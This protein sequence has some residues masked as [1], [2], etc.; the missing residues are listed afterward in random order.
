M[1]V[2]V[3]V[4]VYTARMYVTTHNKGAAQVAD[5]PQALCVFDEMYVSFSLSLHTHISGGTVSMVVPGGPAFKH[6]KH[7]DNEGV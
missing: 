2:C 5:L 1:Q 6:A 3:C 7:A 4:C